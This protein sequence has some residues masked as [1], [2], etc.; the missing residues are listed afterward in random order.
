MIRPAIAAL[1]LLLVAPAARAGHTIAIAYFGD[2]LR[3]DVRVVEVGSGRVA[4]SEKVE[5]TRDDWELVLKAAMPDIF[6]LFRR[7]GRKGRAR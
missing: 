2:S 6:D 4:A 3:V 1:A 5:G 7:Y